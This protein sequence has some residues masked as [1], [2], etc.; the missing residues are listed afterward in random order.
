MEQNVGSGIGI[1]GLGAVGC[2]LARAFRSAGIPIT[3][4]IDVDSDAV[5]FIADELS[6]ENAAVSFSRLDGRT[7][8]LIIAVP[9]DELKNVDGI[10]ARETDLSHFH[11]CAHTSGTYPGD[12]LDEISSA[13]TPVGSLHPL[14][15][16]PSR[17]RSPGLRGAYFA[18]EGNL[19]AVE[20]LTHLVRLIGGIPV[21]IPSAGKPVYH[22]AAVLASNSIQ[23]LLWSAMQMLESLAVPGDDACRML[24]PLMRSSLENSLQMGAEKALTGP[25]A[26]G[27]VATVQRE[28]K[29][30]GDRFPAFFQLYKTLDVIALEIAKG[31]GVDPERLRQIGDLL[32]ESVT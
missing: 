10:L 12:V 11:V 16:F 19:K 4:L 3:A 31:K 2:A 9:D 15:T 25:I 23:V 29:I 8:T 13:G 21:E 1:I 20:H 27:D 30:L 7:G 24:A 22:A 26:R 28:L 5:Q 14:Q 17:E 6:V 32:K 18:V